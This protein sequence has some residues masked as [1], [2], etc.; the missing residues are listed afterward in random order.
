MSDLCGATGSALVTFTA[1]DACGNQSSTTATVTIR[2]ITPPAINTTGKANLTVDCDGTADPGGAIAAWLG[3]H[4]GATATDACSTVSWGHN[5]AGLSD[6]CGATGSALVTF[7][8]TDACGNQSSTTATVTIRDITSPAINTTGKAN[9]TVDCDGTADPGG[10]IAAWLGNHAG[11]TATDACST[12]SWGH[13][14]AGLSDLC[15]ATGSALVTFTATDACGNAST[16]T[17][18]V[19]IRDITPPAINTTGKA[20]L[21]VDCDGTADPG[22]AIAAWLDNHAGA[23]ATDACSTVSWGH[24]YAGLSDLCGATG[25]ALVTFTATDACGNPEFDDSHC[26]DTG[27]HPAGHQ[28]YRQGQP[29]GGLR[30]H[31]R[32]GRGDSRL[33]G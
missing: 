16:T 1:T 14:Y 24:N 25:S 12:V 19:T 3:N 2:D 32:S 23:T 9:L 28:H 30:R 27:Y 18:T 33:A 10:A 6:L 31:R 13:N 17:A 21:T 11:A 4:A 5:Y 29:D 7:T 26:D 15:G 8:A 20:N 22:G